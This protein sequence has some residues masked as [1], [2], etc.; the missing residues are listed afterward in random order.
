MVLRQHAARIQTGGRKYIGE[1]GPTSSLNSRCRRC[2][3]WRAGNVNHEAG[4]NAFVGNDSLKHPSHLSFLKPCS[5]RNQ[6][7]V[8]VLDSPV[9]YG[10]AGAGQFYC[11][12]MLDGRKSSVLFR[13]IQLIVLTSRELSS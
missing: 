5:L 9:T 7:Y 11:K 4:R 10:I 2:P 12:I 13:R 1:D 8:I 6:D 3:L